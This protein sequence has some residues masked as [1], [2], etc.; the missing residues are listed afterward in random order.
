MHSGARGFIF[1]DRI[2]CD[3]EEEIACGSEIVEASK[4]VPCSSRCVW[5][6]VPPCGCVDI[7][8]AMRNVAEGNAQPQ[9]SRLLSSRPDNTDV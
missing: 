6:L 7:S 1:A 9:D 4:V 8:R 2:F 3:S 5:S